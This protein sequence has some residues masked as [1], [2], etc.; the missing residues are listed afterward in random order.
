VLTEEMLLSITIGA[1]NKSEAESGEDIDEGE[2][3]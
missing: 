1:L 2:A 3:F